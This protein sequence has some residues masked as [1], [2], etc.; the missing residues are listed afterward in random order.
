MSAGEEFKPDGYYWPVFKGLSGDLESARRAKVSGVGT[1]L[2]RCV[3][4]GATPFN[5][6]LTVGT[7]DVGHTCCWGT[8]R[9]D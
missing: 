2:M 3:T 5:V 8:L 4:T 7:S 9:G 6:V 1:P